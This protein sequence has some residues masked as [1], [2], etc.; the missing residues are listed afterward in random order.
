MI[1]RTYCILHIEIYLY[2]YLILTSKRA[3]HSLWEHLPILA[4]VTS[5]TS[6]SYHLSELDLGVNLLQEVS[7]II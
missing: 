2:V 5:L 4:R 7:P 3:D 6:N 1:H